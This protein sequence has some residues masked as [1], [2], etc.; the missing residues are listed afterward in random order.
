ME[1]K[2]YDKVMLKIYDTRQEMGMEAAKDAAACIHQLLKEKEE[3]NCMFAAAPSQNEF[4]A[5][6]AADTTI[7]WGRINAYHMD[8]Y[9]GFG[10]GDPRSFNGFL[11]NAIFG[12]VPF[13]TVNL[14]NGQNEP[15][16]ECSR[17]EALLREHPLDIVFMGIGENGHIAF[18]DPPVA[19]FQDKKYIKIVE[20]EQRCRMQQV[21]D[22]CF[23]DIDSVPT[24][25]FTVTIPAMMAARHLFCMVPGK[26]KAHAV[27][28][29]LTGAIETAC[30][31][32]ILRQHEHIQ[33]YI[34]RDCAS[35]L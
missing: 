25:A 1:Q 12:K 14:L 19:D 2:Q 18:N 10:I 24:H 20:L 34:D 22:G 15:E 35:E 33:M 11:T 21:H 28:Q 16:A 32:S 30:P 5:A 29:A 31:A 26:L 3:I 13:K 23:P 8:D 7:P 4:L 17:Y 6:L 9:I 27:R